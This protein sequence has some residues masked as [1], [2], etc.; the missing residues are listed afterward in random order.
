MSNRVEFSSR[1]VG[2]SFST[3]PEFSGSTSQS[4]STLFQK[5]S[6]STRT[7]VPNST[8]SVYLWLKFT[9]D[10]CFQYWFPFLILMFQ[11]FNHCNFVSLQICFLTK[12]MMIIFVLPITD[13]S[14]AAI[15]VNWFAFSFSMMSLQLDTYCMRI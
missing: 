5:N 7:R 14:W 2:S 12:L 13:T 1:V 8:R 3:R 11:T 9:F 15:L 4:D 6:N 10:M